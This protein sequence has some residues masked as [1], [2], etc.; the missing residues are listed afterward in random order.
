MALINQAVGESPCNERSQEI[1]KLFDENTA[2]RTLLTNLSY[3]QSMG[4]F[5]IIENLNVSAWIIIIDVKKWI[6]LLTNQSKWN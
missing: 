2:K 6:L 1:L 3:V 4:I 5:F